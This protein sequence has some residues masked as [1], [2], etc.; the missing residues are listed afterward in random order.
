LDL[1]VIG[2]IKMCH[3]IP[4]TS[5]T[6]RYNRALI[7]GAEMIG[8]ILAGIIQTLVSELPEFNNRKA[9]LV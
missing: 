2:S 6:N 4:A 3:A 7:I 5:N 8:V 1:A 9:V